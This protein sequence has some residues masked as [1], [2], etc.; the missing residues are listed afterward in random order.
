MAQMPGIHQK[1]LPLFMTQRPLYFYSDPFLHFLD[2]TT[3]GRELLVDQLTGLGFIFVG[4][5][6]H[7]FM[8]WFA[9]LKKPAN[10]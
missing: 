8:R 9:H 4:W 6:R 7:P 2:F 10:S 1:V 5:G 3:G